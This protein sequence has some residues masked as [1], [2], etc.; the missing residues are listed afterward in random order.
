MMN[1]NKAKTRDGNEKKGR[2]R[3]GSFGWDETRPV[4]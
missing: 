2:A 3:N 1:Y 4:Q